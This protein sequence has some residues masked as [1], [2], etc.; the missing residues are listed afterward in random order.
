MRRLLDQ[1]AQVPYTPGA[2]GP[3]PSGRN[4]TTHVQ[5]LYNTFIAARAQLQAAQSAYDVASSRLSAAE[6]NH[7][8]AVA[9]LQGAYMQCGPVVGVVPAAGMA[10]TQA[11]AQ[12]TARCR[13]AVTKAQHAVDKMT[14]RV[15]R[16]R[17]QVTSRAKARNAAQAAYMTA[18]D[19]YRAVTNAP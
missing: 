5:R 3:L 8:Q 1:S 17:A 11:Q 12:A 6:H 9:N 13:A 15:Q 19:A 2:A 14:S 4:W 7:A 10:L 18:L 16:Y